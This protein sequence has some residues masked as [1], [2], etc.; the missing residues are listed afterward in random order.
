MTAA[1]SYIIEQSLLQRIPITMR[2][3]LKVGIMH[4]WR[5]GSCRSGIMH[6][7]TDLCVCPVAVPNIMEGTFLLQLP[8]E[9]SLFM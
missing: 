8:Q 7:N 1:L 5:T 3:W 4:P 6:D 2:L 9:K